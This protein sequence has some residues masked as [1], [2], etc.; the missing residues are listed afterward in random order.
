MNPYLGTKTSE[1]ALMLAEQCLKADTFAILRNANAISNAIYVSFYY[2]AR[3][4]RSGCIKLF[5]SLKQITKIGDGVPKLYW[6]YYAG[7]NLNNSRGENDFIG[8]LISVLNNIT[9]DMVLRIMDNVCPLQITEAILGVVGRHR[10]ESLFAAA[11]S[12]QITDPE[13]WNIIATSIHNL[14]YENADWKGLKTAGQIYG[15]ARLF[16]TGTYVT[17]EKYCYNYIRTLT[18]YYKRS[19]VAFPSLFISSV[20]NF[21]KLPLSRNFT[22]KFEALK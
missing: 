7:V 19:G 15:L 6:A 22:Y 1:T 21:L 14:S 5:E 16:T 10:N 13:V 12:Q 18:E 17:G 9:D 8:E 3:F 11:C 4:K 20:V 2:G